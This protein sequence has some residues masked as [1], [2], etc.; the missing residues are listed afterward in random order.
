MTAPVHSL[1]EPTDHPPLAPWSCQEAPLEQCHI[2]LRCVHHGASHRSLRSL[3]CKLFVSFLTGHP[4]SDP[5]TPDSKTIVEG[6]G[7]RLPQRAESPSRQTGGWEQG[8]FHRPQ[9]ALLSCLY[10]LNLLHQELHYNWES[11]FTGKGTEL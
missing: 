3:N 11:P 2:A 6:M 10:H 8:S 9:V 7:G 5:L 1:P 4:R